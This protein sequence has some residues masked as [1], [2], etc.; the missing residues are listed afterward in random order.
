MLAYESHDTFFMVPEKAGTADRSQAFSIEEASDA[1]AA[2]LRFELA[3]C[4]A[5]MRHT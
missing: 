2:G 1:K 5:E 4:E 3:D